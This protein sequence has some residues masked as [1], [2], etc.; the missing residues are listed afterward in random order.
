MTSQQYCR[1]GLKIIEGYVCQNCSIE[2]RMDIA[3]SIMDGFNKAM[4]KQ[5]KK[6]FGKTIKEL[7][8]L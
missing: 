8:H 3:K 7:L 6:V 2:D 1:H 5:E 4:D